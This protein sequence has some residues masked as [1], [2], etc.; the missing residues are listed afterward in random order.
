M[1]G[2]S[3]GPVGR[4]DTIKWSGLTVPGSNG[5][6]RVRLGLG[7][8]MPPVWTSIRRYNPTPILDPGSVVGYSISNGYPYIYRVELSLFDLLSLERIVT[9]E[10][11]H[12]AS[13]SSMH[14]SDAVIPRLG[15]LDCIV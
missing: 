6:G 7:L 9:V 4:H 15:H 14:L 12:S 2:K 11:E 5:S 10:G 13:L 1:L 3:N 8:A